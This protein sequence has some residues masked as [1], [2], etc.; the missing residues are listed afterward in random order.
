MQHLY[1]QIDGIDRSSSRHTTLVISWMFVYKERKTQKPYY[2]ACM[3]ERLAYQLDI[4]RYS[5]AGV[6]DR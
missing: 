3:Q 6:I 1:K 5:R 4:R 2:N